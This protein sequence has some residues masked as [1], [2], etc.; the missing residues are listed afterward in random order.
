MVTCGID[1]IEADIGFQEAT[2]VRNMKCG[3]DFGATHGERDQP[4]VGHSIGE[5]IRVRSERVHRFDALGVHRP[6]DEGQIM[7]LLV[8]RDRAAQRWRCAR[9]SREPVPLVRLGGRRVGCRA[10]LLI[11]YPSSSPDI[12][13][14]MLA[15]VVEGST[16]RPSSSLR[17]TS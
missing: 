8:E 5:N 10:H 2:E 14:S 7:P 4:D 12:P 6:M 11:G 3:A 9:A 15:R 16:R 17:A 13:R 1:R